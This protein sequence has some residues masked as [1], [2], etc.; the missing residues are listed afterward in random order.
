MGFVVGLG[1]FL[2][3][4]EFLVVWL[5]LCVAVIMNPFFFIIVIGFG[6]YGV[7]AF[8]NDCITHPEIIGFHVRFSLSVLLY[9][10]LA[11]VS[12]SLML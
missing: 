2:K 5:P 12:R 4:L 7:V 11:S 8:Y 9:F 6:W 10:F 1:I 3:K